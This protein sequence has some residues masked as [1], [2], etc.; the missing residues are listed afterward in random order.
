MKAFLQSRAMFGMF[1]REIPNPSNDDM[2]VITTDAFQSNFLVPRMNGS[3]FMMRWVQQQGMGMAQ[4]CS[5]SG[6]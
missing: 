5:K 4:N 6:R 2:T 3:R 1:V